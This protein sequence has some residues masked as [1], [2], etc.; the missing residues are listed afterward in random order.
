[1]EG[2]SADALRRHL[3]AALA[4]LRLAVPA[5]EAPADPE[6]VY[7]GGPALVVPLAHPF[8]L[9]DRR[10][11]EA[12]LDPPPLAVV[13]AL[14]E[15]GAT[16]LRS[17]LA[18][19]TDLPPEVVGHLRWPDA[20][21]LLTAARALL[22]PGLLPA[23]EAPG[24]AEAGPDVGVLPAPTGPRRPPRLDRP[25]GRRGRSPRRT[26]RD[27]GRLPRRLSPVLLITGL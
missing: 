17:V 23:P 15:A 4:A 5:A 21:A 10:F 9:G 16:D 3:E 1:M 8:T 25:R 20:E 22:P 24:R 7:E 13:E 6:P 11:A 2:A 27:D 19:T 18:A 12:K 26:A 14:V